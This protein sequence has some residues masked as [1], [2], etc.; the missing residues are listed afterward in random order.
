MS[1]RYSNELQ[2]SSSVRERRNFY[3]I[4]DP[5]PRSLSSTSSEG[6]KITHKTKT[7]YSDN[8]FTEVTSDIILESS[9]EEK[10]SSLKLQS[11]LPIP[12]VRTSYLTATNTTAA[13]ATGNLANS[14][15]TRHVTPYT[16]FGNLPEHRERELLKRTESQ[17]ITITYLNNKFK[18]DR[19]SR[20]D[21][22]ISK[23]VSTTPVKKQYNKYHQTDKQMVPVL[24]VSESDHR[25]RTP[26][27]EAYAQATKN[28]VPHIH[29]PDSNFEYRWRDG[30][31]IRSA[32]NQL[33][34]SSRCGSA[35]SLL[36]DNNDFT[37]QDLR[38]HNAPL[39]KR[40]C[41]RTPSRRGSA[42]SYDSRRSISPCDPKPFRNSGTNNIHFGKAPNVPVNFTNHP[43]RMA[44][45]T[46]I[47]DRIK[48]FETKVNIDKPLNGALRPSHSYSKSHSN[49]SKKHNLDRQQSEPRSKFKNHIDKEEDNGNATRSK[50][51]VNLN[52]QTNKTADSCIIP[53]KI[54]KEKQN[55][56]KIITPKTYKEIKSEIESEMREKQNQKGGTPLTTSDTTGTDSGQGSS[57]NEELPPSNQQQKYNPDE[58]LPGEKGYIPAYKN[59]A[60]FQIYS[61]KRSQVQDIRDELYKDKQKELDYKQRVSAIKPAGYQTSMMTKQDSGGFCT[62]TTGNAIVER[63]SIGRPWS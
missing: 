50:S 24:K 39:E 56:I 9:I 38:K 53:S 31:K 32:K 36:S 44:A 52:H 33:E 23:S 41:S 46:P 27:P 19:Q 37:L 63:K 49:F 57:P 28:E 58:P 59:Q 11:R 30:G 25:F 62:T 18:E 7:S 2:R 8:E 40:R 10:Y 54:S 5:E 42:C 47:T 14:N 51:Y 3:S 60:N 22:R 12:K 6:F 17:N 1:K 61:A 21:M 43:S 45:R 29:E 35:T 13:S 34:A 16:D 48:M 20:Q 4:K 15:L 26:S 55:E